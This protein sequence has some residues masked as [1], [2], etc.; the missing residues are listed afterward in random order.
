MVSEYNV[1]V[2]TYVLD[3]RMFENSYSNGVKRNWVIL[4]CLISRRQPSVFWMLMLGLLLSAYQP[5]YRF[6]ESTGGWTI[7]Y[8]YIKSTQYYR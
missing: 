2:G 7:K 3:E 8:R 6:I 5:F 1:I 4:I